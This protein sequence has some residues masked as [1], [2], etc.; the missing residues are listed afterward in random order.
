MPPPIEGFSVPL[1]DISLDDK[2]ARRDGKVYM[3]GNQ[4]LVRAAL[5]QRWR[6]EASGLNTAGF[7]SGYRGSPLHNVDKELWR[8]DQALDRSHIHFLPG[9]NEDLA[10]TAIW[11][12]QQANSFGDA[13]YDGVY[14]MWYGKGPGFDRSVDAIRH[15]HMAGS[16]RHGGVL[17]VVGD[18][19]PMK[20]SASPAAHE[21]LFA[22]LMMPVLFP[23]NVQ[24]V[25]DYALYG[26]AL[27][28]FAGTWV[29]LKMIPDTI[30][31]TTSVLGETDRVRIATPTECSFPRDGVNLRVPDHYRH[32]EARTRH[33]KIPAAIAFAKA[34]GINRVTHASPNPR[35]G[36][37]ATGKAW[38][39][40]CQAFREMAL[41]EDQLRALGITVLK[42]GM[43][44]PVD[45]SAI[46]EF[47]A[48]LEEILIVE[49]KHRL[50]ETNVKDVL[51]A[52]PDDRRPR[53]IG[54][55]D[56][57]GQMIL[58]DWPEFTPDD[59]VRALAGRIAHFHSSEPIRARLDFLRMRKERAAQR[60][61]LDIERLPFFCS[62]CPHNTSTQVPEGS[63]AHGGIGCHML[64]TFMDR[65]NITHTH[66][67]GEGANWLGQAPFVKTKHVFQNI[68]DGTYFHS[69]Q[70]AVRAAVAADA[71]MTFKILFND[72][73]AMTGG[74]PVEGTLS[75]QIISR[76]VYD[77]GVRRIAVVSDEPEKY[78]SGDFA[79]EVTIDHRRSLD[80]VQRE[81]RK[82]PGTS[83]LIYDQTCAAEKRRKRKSGR[84][85]DPPRRLFVNDLV[86]EGCGDCNAKSNCLSVLPLET[87]FGRK[88]YIDQSQCNKDYSCVEGFCPSFVS[89]VGS[90]PRKTGAVTPPNMSSAL[91]EPDRPE[92]AKSGTYNI[93]VT[94]VGG[95][96]VV[97]ITALLTMAAHIEGMAFSSIDQTGISQKGG[98]V[99]SHLR[100]AGRQHDINSVRLNE[101]A[102][103]LVIGCDNVTTAG[104]GTLSVISSERTKVLL[105]TYEQITGDFVEN[106]DQAFPAATVWSRIESVAGRD[107]IT[108]VDA[109]RLATRLLGDSIA[110]NMFL[111]GYAYQSGMIP[112]TASAIEKAIELNGVA[113]E[114]NKNAFQ[115]GRRTA[116]A[117]GA[118]EAVV[119]FDSGDRDDPKT[120]EDLIVHREKDLTAY[121]NSA[122]A[123]RYRNLVERARNAEANK[124]GGLSGLAD[125]VARNAYQLMAYKDEYEVA[126]LYTDGRFQAELI[127]SF[128]D[129]GVLEIHLAPPWLARPDPETGVPAKRAYGSWILP[130]LRQ[131]AKLKGLRNTPFD[132]FG[133]SD[134]RKAERQLIVDYENTIEWLSQGLSTENHGL[135]VEIASVPKMIRGYGHVKARNLKEA[136]AKQRELRAIWERQSSRSRNVA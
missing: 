16:S 76:Q 39:D 131:L 50:T 110:A 10:A 113:V 67:G 129:S 107:A 53:V 49:E 48:G 136:E 1:D 79:S 123:E 19:H 90:L 80:R 92:I 7:I 13:D 21:L 24:E 40:L 118:V 89:V 88:R 23:A 15:A 75:P 121:Q 87:E 104:D 56:E 3:T 9:V 111:L 100:L 133:Y 11:G 91:P 29:G 14:A 47:A 114:L 65:G 93:M 64:A 122:Y 32:Q 4:A 78:K 72:A 73:I 125:A 20:E 58:P 108:A 71:N 25:I 70:L 26:W 46:R 95:T 31:A 37:V 43:P 8:A 115:W 6:D 33:F 30:A 120:L 54:R 45:E 36:I 86:C 103:D 127:K 105:N 117:P 134:E 41:D 42:L 55:F 98:S 69:G 135:A 34:N 5:M 97:T 44:Y 109:T 128:E 126:R 74:Q 81:L 61:L 60:E 27:S 2:Y 94:G 99:V 112:V 83:V 51:Y 85:I 77:E 96:G 106:P 62:G 17:A 28:R 132:P 130:V 66:M 18:D 59:V 35:Y 12:S 22:D 63:R 57:S 124:A 119:S 102:A 82:Y 101:G 116:Y 84:M 68:G 38:T 52:L